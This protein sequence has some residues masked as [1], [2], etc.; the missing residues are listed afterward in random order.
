LGVLDA[1]TDVK[2]AN[3]MPLPGARD[4]M[5]KRRGDAKAGRG[6]VHGAS[7]DRG[8]FNYYEAFNKQV[9]YCEEITQNLLSAFKAG[10]MGT[11]QLMAALH[12]VENDADSVDHD[13]RIHLLTDLIVPADRD[14]MVMLA[15]SV[16]NATDKIEDIAIFAYIY[17]AKYMQPRMR[18]VLEH[19]AASVTLLR[20]ACERM[21]SYERFYD[22]I[23]VRV[24][25]VAQ[26]ESACDAIFISTM[27]NLYAT[28]EMTGEKRQITAALYE[29]FEDAMD[30]LEQVAESMEAIISQSR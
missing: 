21:D 4:G 17:G 26:R 13:L 15:N 14:G 28:D 16:E 7:R 19:M 2:A 18:D 20:E 27:H 30:S 11:E 25:G 10:E 6:L 3:P 12:V 24:T 1:F 29:K 5:A 9:G 22:E 8:R 23:Y